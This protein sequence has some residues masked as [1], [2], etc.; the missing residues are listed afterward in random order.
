MARCPRCHDLLL[1][2]DQRPEQFYVGTRVFD[3]VNVGL[4][5]D[6][7]AAGN[8]QLFHARDAATHAPIDGNS[9]EGHD[10]WQCHAFA[11]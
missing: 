11:A 2:P 9:N 4:R 5:T 6:P 3:P 10:I 8:S 7:D 1:P